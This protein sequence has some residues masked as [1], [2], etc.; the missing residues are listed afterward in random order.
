VIFYY[1]IVELAKFEK[2]PAGLTI[3]ERK[4]LGNKFDKKTM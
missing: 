4:T 2:A 1:Y 3:E